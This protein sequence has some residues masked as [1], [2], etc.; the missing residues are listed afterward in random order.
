MV[1]ALFREYAAGVGVDL[2]FQGFDAEVATLPGRYAPPTGRL[3][4][5]RRGNEAVGCVGLRALDDGVCEMK[6]LYVRPD[7]RGQ[8]VGRQ[9]VERICDHARA[10]RYARLCLDTLPSMSA[11]RALYRSLGFK[12]IE[13]YVHNPIAGA[14]YLALEL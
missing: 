3:L 12:P 13:P 14:E 5:A 8:N 1:R 10:L 2:C 4:L 11:A 6:R 9:L 7:V